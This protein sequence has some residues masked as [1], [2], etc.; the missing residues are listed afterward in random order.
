MADRVHAELAQD[1]RPVFREILQAQQV[2]LEV[3]LIVQVNIEAG[4]IDVLRQEKFRRRIA[5][6]GKKNVRI[7]FAPDADE[8]LDEFGHPPHAEPAH[9]R[10]RD[11]VPDKITED[12]RVT[13]MLPRPLSEPIATIFAARFL[14]AEIRRASPRAA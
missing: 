9:H 6:V 8:L 4:E 3:A 11:L 14:G 13:A 2:A 12:R 7:G 5:R 10:A 1:E